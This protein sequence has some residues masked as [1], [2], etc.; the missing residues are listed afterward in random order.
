MARRRGAS[1][2]PPKL[3]KQLG[4]QV[5][6]LTTRKRGR[7]FPLLTEAQPQWV[8]APK[9]GRGS[10]S[11]KPPVVRDNIVELLGDRPRV[12]LFAREH[13]PG[14]NAWGDEIWPGDTDSP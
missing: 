11:R 10:H 12:E 13:P 7:V 5:I 4:E 9:P 3:V 2:P 1:G 8:F 14:W 6:A